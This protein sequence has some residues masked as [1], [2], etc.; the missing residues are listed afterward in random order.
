MAAGLVRLFPA[1]GRVRVVRAWGVPTAFTADDEPLVGWLPERDN[2]FVAAA[3][4]ETI[5]ALPVASEWMAG[6]ILGESIPVDLS[7]YIPD[8]FSRPEAAASSG[9]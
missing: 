6:M 3:F 5:T 7:R 9:D 8:R 2:L 1:L 4:L